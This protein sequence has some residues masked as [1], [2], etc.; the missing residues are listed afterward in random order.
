MFDAATPGPPVSFRFF[1][2][3]PFFSFLLLFFS[4]FLVD[5]EVRVASSAGP[6][7]EGSHENYARVEQILEDPE[8]RERTERRDFERAA[9][10]FPSFLPFF[11]F[12]FRSAARL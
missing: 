5:N 8:A 2:Y 9:I 10:P 4:C 3:L 11:L 6:C 7:I 12:S 1:S